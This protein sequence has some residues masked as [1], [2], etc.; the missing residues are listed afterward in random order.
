[1]KILHLCSIPPHKALL[2]LF[3]VLALLGTAVLIFLIRALFGGVDAALYH[4]ALPL[5]L[6]GPVLSAGLGLYQTVSLPPHRELKAQFQVVSLLYGLI[7]A[8]LFLS[9]SGDVYSRIVVAGSW[10]ATLVTLPCMRTLCR[11]L[12]ARHRWWGKQLVIFDRSDVGRELWHTL[13]RCPERGL[14]PVDIIALPKDPAA[15][16]ACLAS[17]G[18]RWPSAVALLLQKADQGLEVDHIAAASRYFDNVL[19]VPFFGPAARTHWLT[20]RDLGN[21]VGLLVR[22]NLHDKR[23]LRFKRCMDIALCAAGA[24]VLLPLGLLLALAIRLDSP[25]PVFYR[26]TRLGR[27]GRE[28]RIFKF[29]TMVTNADQ[30]LAEVLRRDPTLRAE[31]QRNQKLRADP[32]ITRTGH[33]LRKLSLDELPQLLNVVTG[34]MS[35]VGPRPIVAGERE[36]YGPVYEEYCMVRP[37]ITG[38]WQ[39]SGRNNTSYEERVAYD[40]YYI[41]N[42]SVWM[43]LWIMARTV[44]VVLTGYGAY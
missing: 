10:A 41:N 6:L 30:T 14:N 28:I 16:H 36:K 37:G 27:H 29:R 21:S 34:D 1:M 19:L 3:D 12:F 15:A 39:I 32:R 43:D 4:W 9:H 5:L 42:W 24:V 26:Q 40:H 23:R 38:L 20:P 18:Q 17:A 25:G 44:P 35:L 31:W 2:C 33:L 13:K 11:R 7:L 8:V 22:Q